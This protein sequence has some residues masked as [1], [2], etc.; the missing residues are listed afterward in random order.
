MYVRIGYRLS[1][2]DMGT[3]ARICR[4]GAILHCH[5]AAARARV[6][7]GLG[8]GLG[9]RGAG[10]DVRSAIDADGPDYRKVEAYIVDISLSFSEKKQANIEKYIAISIHTPTT[11]VC[12]CV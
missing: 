1:S 2:L 8:L 6:Q 3:C 11:T 7:L 12:V 5:W 4:L 9:F 10:V